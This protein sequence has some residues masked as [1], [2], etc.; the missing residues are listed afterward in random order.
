MY[1][2]FEEIYSVLVFFFV[3][4]FNQVICRF[5]AIGVFYIFEILVAYRIDCKHACCFHPRDNLTHHPEGFFLGT[6]RVCFSS[7]S[8][9][10]ESIREK[11]N[12]Q[13][14]HFDCSPSV[15]SHPL[16]T[17]Q[18]GMFSRMFLHADGY[19][20]YGALDSNLVNW[21]IT[22]LCLF[23]TQQQLCSPHAV[24]SLRSLL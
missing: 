6:L 2:L 5:G 16:R 15:H 14:N 22:L 17:A 23:H 11:G 1:I 24:S 21:N 7:Q 9:M 8:C 10:R 13:C 18:G 4:F 12:T 19:V 3:H 20:H